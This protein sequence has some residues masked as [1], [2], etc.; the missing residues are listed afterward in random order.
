M[1]KFRKAAKTSILYKFRAILI[2]HISY[3]IFLISSTCAL[4][5]IS[6]IGE[7]LSTGGVQYINIGNYQSQSEI[8][9]VGKITVFKFQSL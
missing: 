5:G 3:L 7:I 4:F 1:Y 8:R 6:A 2:L 9:M